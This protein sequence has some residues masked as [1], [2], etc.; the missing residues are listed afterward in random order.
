MDA[1][2][3]LVA[4]PIGNLEDITLRALRTLRECDL[5]ACEDTR[6]TRKLL[7]RYEIQKPLVSCH[8]HNEH[9]RAREIV[10]RVQ[11]GQAVAIVSDAGLPGI[12]DPG[13]RVVQAAIAA[14]VR[15]IPIPGPSAVD[16]AVVASGL[17]TDSFLY[18]GF[19]PAKSGQRIKALEDLASEAPTLVFYEAP[20]RLLRTLEDAQSVLGDRQAVVAREL[21]K[22]HEEFLRGTLSE[23]HAGLAA[24]ESVKGEIV[25]LIAGAGETA[26]PAATM[27]LAERVRRLIAEGASPMDAVK[28]AAKEYGVSKRE[29]YNLVEL[30]K[31]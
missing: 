28:T 2:V 7:S 24:R 20:H 10:E 13:Y 21:T 19:L 4:T 8:E 26:T 30:N 11:A 29:A 27:P 18:L 5:I 1:A 3:Y 16:T 6:H 9:E 22:T 31:T 23:I 14:G 12:S 15:V 25:L 17:P